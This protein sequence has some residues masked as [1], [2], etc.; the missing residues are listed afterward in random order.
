MNQKDRKMGPAGSNGLRMANGQDEK[1]TRRSQT[2]VGEEENVG[3][4]AEYS[5]CADTHSDELQAAL[6]DL[7]IAI[8]NQQKLS[9][10]KG[11]A[12]RL[13]DQAI[14]MIDVLMD[15][16]EFRTCP[17]CEQIVNRDGGHLQGC[18]FLELKERRSL[19]R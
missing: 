14:S 2:L 15:E 10:E 8:E 9:K 12:L 6:A 7:K 5:A 11:K 17:W 18:D 16:A 13:L 3:K 1:P 4:D 19:L